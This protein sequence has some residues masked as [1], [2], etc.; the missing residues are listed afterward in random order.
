MPLRKTV[1]NESD[2]FNRF[3]CV[4]GVSVV[5]KTLLYSSLI[6]YKVLG[7]S[8]IV[9]SIASARLVALHNSLQYLI[10]FRE[11]KAQ[12]IDILQNLEQVLAFEL[13]HRRRQIAALFERC[14]ECRPCLFAA[15]ACGPWRKW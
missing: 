12:A 5:A 4:V 11:A 8:H 2:P 6:A 7:Y 15:R 10:R 9:T 14:H 3:G 1:F 13:L